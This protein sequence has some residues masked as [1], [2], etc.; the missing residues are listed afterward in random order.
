MHKLLEQLLREAPVVTDGAWGTSLQAKGLETG[1]CPDE[2]NLSHPAQ[3]EEVARS[4]VQAGTRIILTN[5]FGAN[6]LM[7][8]RHGLA[9]KAAE[10]NRTGV[11][12]S[13][14]AA[15]GDNALVFASIG[16][17]G[18]MLMMGEVSEDE[19]S[20]AF[21]EQAQS[22]AEGGADGLLLETMTD[23]AEAKLAVQAAAGTGLPVVA[24]LVYDSGAEFDRTMMGNTPEQAAAELRAAGADILGANCGQGIET[25]QV[26]C[27]RLHEAAGAPVWIK[28][29]AGLPEIVEGQTVFRQSPAAFAEQ[30]PALVQAGAGFIGGCCG[31][32]PDFIRAIITALKP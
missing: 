29:N 5:T 30:V 4:Y 17:S 9:D 24:S 25:F 7:L 26:V 31:T 22:L 12:I 8:A 11:E 2:W 6:R 21:R 1:G 10:I 23:L 28:P 16:P 27:R 20:D 13:K 3:V 32:N 14:R 15:A 19:V 18:V